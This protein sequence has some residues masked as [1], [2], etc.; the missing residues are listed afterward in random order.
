MI[1]GL[2]IISLQHRLRRSGWRTGYNGLPTLERVETG[3]RQYSEQ[4]PLTLKTIV[5]TEPFTQ[6]TTIITS[7]GI[8]TVPKGPGVVISNGKYLGQIY[9]RLPVTTDE[10]NS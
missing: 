6:Y 3:E 10:N 4:N 7:D 5:I 2:K 1:E 8:A 9:P